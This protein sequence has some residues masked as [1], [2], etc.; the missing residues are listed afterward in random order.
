MIHSP[1]KSWLIYTSYQKDLRKKS[2]DFSNSFPN[3]LF[4]LT[5]DDKWR[6]VSS[7]VF[8]YIIWLV[9]MKINGEGVLK[10]QT[11][12]VSESQDQN[13]CSPT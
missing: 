5:S 12:R 4:Q 11:N 13:F 10:N 1:I 3:T 2:Y 8:F 6:K 7:S 9:S